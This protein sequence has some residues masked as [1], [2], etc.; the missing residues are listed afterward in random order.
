MKDGSRDPQPSGQGDNR[1]ALHERDRL[2][3]LEALLEHS[4]EGISMFDAEANIVYEHPANERITGYPAGEVVGRNLFEFCHPDDAGRLVPRFARLAGRPGEADSDVVRWRHK[5]GRWIYLEGTVV[6][7]LHHPRLRGMINTFRDVTP[8]IEMEQQLKAAHAAAEENRQVQQ[9]FLA[10][11]SHELRT[12]LTLVKQPVEELI[13]DSADPRADIAR[14]NFRRLDSLVNELVDLTRLDAGIFELRVREHPVKELLE[15]WLR[16]IEPLA[17][18]R[19]IRLELAPPDGDLRVF[20]DERKLAKA[21]L[22]LLHNA[23]QY[24]PARSVVTLACLEIRS[25]TASSPRRLRIEVR[26]RGPAIPR[27]LRERMFERFYQGA[28]QDESAGGMGLGLAIAREMVELHGGEV[29]LRRQRGTNCFRIEIPMDADHLAPHEIETTPGQSQ[30]PAAPERLEIIPGPT[31]ARSPRPR[32]I[33][34]PEGRRVLVA[35]DNADLR[36]YLAFHLES[37]YEL[38]FAVD[39][40]E[41]YDIALKTPPDLLLSDIMMPGL[42]GLALTRSLRGHFPPERLRIVLLSAKGT[43]HD[44]VAGLAAGADDYLAKPF[45]IHELLLRMHHLFPPDSD[46]A[47]DASSGWV[48]KVHAVLREHLEDPGFGVSQWAAALGMS[49][50]QMQRRFAH[51]FGTRPI[52]FLRERRL[53]HGRQLLESGGVLTVAEAARRAG[54]TPSYFTRFF[55]STYQMTPTQWLLQNQGLLAE[56]PSGTKSKDTQKNS[57]HYLTFGKKT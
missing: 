29:G 3:L 45:S 20:L 13:A 9:R 7:Q 35:E 52:T 49:T 32:P 24:G 50:R 19:S 46:E 1:E 15:G 34:R 10:N 30:T 27:N 41:A 31:V 21:V 38:T 57:R 14:R 16:E 47:P 55:T 48:G 54:M 2:A 22:N 39:G 17:Q 18:A 53:E 40:Q 11:L 25:G 8:R 12:P 37:I 5:D 44:R 56:I 23:I 43:H 36:N 33:P 51:V 28:A 26:D 6:N 42:D 4:Y